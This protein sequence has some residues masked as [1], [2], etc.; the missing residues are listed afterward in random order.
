MTTIKSSE[1]ITNSDGSIFHLHLH[2]GEIAGKVILVGDPGRVEI[3]AGHFDRVELRRANRE[4]HAITGVYRGQRLSVLS[5]GIGT[6]NVDIVMNELDALVNIDLATRKIRET[7]QTLDIVRV[8]TSGVIQPDVPPGAFILTET[9]IGLDGVLRY[10]K[11]HEHARDTGIETAFI[12]QCRWPADL[13]RPYAV[14]SSP[15]LV[16]RLH[17]E[18]ITHKGITLTANGFYG[19]QG[20]VLRLPLQE[21]NANERVARFAYRGAR[22][23]NYEME[24]AAIAGLAALMGHRAVAICLAIV[25]RATGETLPDRAT[26]VEQLVAYTLE[27]LTRQPQNPLS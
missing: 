2:P 26:R 12:E 22:V 5:T 10:Y 23:V 8:G 20:R 15:S 9:S 17:V 14:H 21:E 27:Q 18:G 6:D 11:G 4:F 25:N 13:A 1:L 24:S 19:P 3:I 7:R 16:E